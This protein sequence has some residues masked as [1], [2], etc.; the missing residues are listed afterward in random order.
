[1]TAGTAASTDCDVLFIGGGIAGLACASLLDQLTERRLSIGIVETRVPAPLPAD[2]EAGLRVFAIAPGARAVLEA[3]GAW[4]R[5]PPS[6]AGAYERMRIFGPDST[7]YG[8]GSIGFD[9]ASQGLAELGHIVEH[10]W[11]RLALWEC[12]P[13]LLFNAA[14]LAF[15]P[16]PEAMHVQLA[17]GSVVRTRLLVGSDGP[18][19]R[20]REQLGVRCTTRDYRQSAIVAHVRSERPHERTAWQHFRRSGPVALLP[21]A[22]GRS[23]IVWS[24]FTAEAGELMA[25]PDAEFNVRLTEATGQVLGELELTTRRLAFPLAARHAHRYTGARFAL[26][27]DAAHQIHPLAGQGINQGLLDAAV[28][29]DTL[30]THLGAGPLADPG[31]ALVLRRHERQRKGANLMTMAAMEGLHGMFTSKAVAVAAMATKGLG[32]VDRLPLL[33]RWLADQAAGTT[34]SSR[35]WHHHKPAT[36][37][38]K[39]T[40]AP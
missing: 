4:S 12:R 26:I 2:A 30:T 22:D 14:A 40:G 1:V 32:I 35:R 34:A 39:P 38:A 27:G 17:D 25:L 9:A 37:G 28:L 36:P 18:D 6:R 7:P 29:A 13:S 3:A 8:S 23:S 24:C 10:D 19:S 15:E 16:R 21:M 33:K 20:V 5:L 11:L 31:D